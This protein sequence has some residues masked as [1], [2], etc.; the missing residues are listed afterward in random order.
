MVAALRGEEKSQQSNQ[1]Q[2]QVPHDPEDLAPSGLSAKVVSGDDGVI[3]GVALAWNAPAEDA[4]SVTGYEILRAVGDGDLTTL[5]ADTEST[6]TTHT[7]ATAAEAGESYA[8]SVKALRGEEAS[9]PSDRA[10]AVIPKVT[11]VEPEPGIA[12]RQT[13]TEVWSA[14]LSVKETIAGDS[15]GCNITVTGKECSSLLDD[16]D[17][18]YN[19][20]TYLITHLYTMSGYLVIGFLN[21]LGE[22]ANSFVLNAGGVTFGFQDTDVFVLISNARVWNRLGLTVWADG[23]TVSVSIAATP[24]NAAPEFSADSATREVPE[25]SAAANVGDPVTATDAD[26]GDTLTY[27]LEGSDAAFFAIDSSSGQIRTK[28]GVTYDHEANSSYSV[29]V[30]AD[31]SNGGTDTIAVTINVLDVNEPPSAPATPTVSAVSGTTDSLS[32]GWTAPDNSGKPDIESYDLRYRKGTSGS[33][34]DGPQDET[35]ISATLTGLDVG[36][37]YQ[38]QVSATNDEG[39]STWSSAGTGTTNA[40]APPPPGPP[41]NVVATPF[42]GRVTLDWDPPASAGDV[43]IGHYEYRLQRGTGA[44]SDWERV[45][46]KLHHTLGEDGTSLVF[47]NKYI[48]AD[49]TFTYEVRAV[50]AG[51]PGRALAADAIDLPP[52]TTFRVEQAE[53]RV[54]EGA[55]TVTVNAVLEIP[56]DWGPYDNDLSFTFT[57]NPVTATVDEDYLTASVV[58]KFRPEDYEEVNGRWIATRGLEVTI[59][60]DRLDEDEESFTLLL[61]RYPSLFTWVQLNT[62]STKLTTTVVIEDNDEL[63]WSVTAEPDLIWEEG[64]VSTVTVGTNDVEFTAAQTITLTLGTE[65]TAATP[66]TDFTVTDSSGATLTAPYTLTLAQGEVDVALVVTAVADT[67]A[68]DDET[69][70]FTATLGA[71]QIGETETLT[72]AEEI[73]VTYPFLIIRDIGTNSATVRLSFDHLD[74]P[75]DEVYLQYGPLPFRDLRKGNW[76]DTKTVRVLDRDELDIRLE[77]L[78]GATRYAVRVSLDPTFPG[79]STRKMEFTTRLRQS[80]G[81]PQLPVPHP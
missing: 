42:T 49:E 80:A 81:V 34:T 11:A 55:G 45:E 72:I 2:V 27:T 46:D 32:V 39:D 74:E 54:S 16:D 22:D 64:G 19:G 38:V 14:T 43:P 6:A 28:A 17:F 50:N 10:L 18:T 12:E 48:R 36:S 5:V 26:A 58:L 15:Y 59:L 29:T 61:E 23:E 37:E 66:G 73:L 40:Q 47:R 33:W 79:E 9:Q 13:T 67:V 25:N 1:A 51:G 75:K 7:D 77:D 31:D 44:F 35:G 63:A 70:T 4:A 30:K 53:V 52:I 69:V 21:D 20:A 8:Y 65:S 41:Q 71:E 78:E 57:T 56:A 60:D 62:D 68:D 76:G 24:P 3:E